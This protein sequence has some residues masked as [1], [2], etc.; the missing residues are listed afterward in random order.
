MANLIHQPFQM[1]MMVKQMA[2]IPQLLREVHK[3]EPIPVH[4]ANEKSLGY[5]SSLF[6]QGLLPFFLSVYSSYFIDDVRIQA[7]IEQRPASKN[8]KQEPGHK[9]IHFRKI[10]YKSLS[11]RLVFCFISPSFL[12]VF[13]RTLS[14][15]K[16]YYSYYSYY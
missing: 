2:S 8:R 7:I 11:F 10:V 5:R 14:K 1:A 6:L 12:S 4:Q 13:L 3:M 15:S 9:H 16:Y